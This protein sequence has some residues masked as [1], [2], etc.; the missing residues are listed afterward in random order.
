MKNFKFQKLF[1]IGLVASSLCII[2]C[3]EEEDPIAAPKASFTTAIDGKTVVFTNTSEGEE[4]T[5]AWDFGDGNTSTEESPTHT[6]E[7][8]GSY[9]AKL[10]A[11]NESGEDDSQSAIEIINITIDGDLSDWADVPALGFTG[12]GSFKEVKMENLGNQ[13]LYVYIKGNS[14]A[15]SFLDLWI[16]LDYE[17]TINGGDSTGYSNAVLYPESNLGWDVLF[18]GFFGSTSGR[19]NFSGMFYGVFYTE[20]EDDLLSNNTDFANRIEPG[21][22]TQVQFSEWVETEGDVEY[23]FVIDLQSFPTNLIPEE[24]ARIQFFIDEWANSPE[25][26]DGWW[27]AF[28]GHYPVQGQED[29]SAAVYTLK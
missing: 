23:E 18:E 26:T 21:F 13:K 2:S 20:D 15:T 3:G 12:D 19:D 22:G 17:S 6:Y 10:V 11:T 1:L 28:A 9:I 14:S 7:A 27:A 29:S 8:N 24:G 25:S 5:Y 4:T 16:N